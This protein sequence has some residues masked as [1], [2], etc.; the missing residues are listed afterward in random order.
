MYRPSPFRAAS[1][2]LFAAVFTVSA[3]AQNARL[4]PE[5]ELLTQPS[6]ADDMGAYFLPNEESKAIVTATKA[7]AFNDAGLAAYSHQR[8][9]QAVVAFRRSIE[10]DPGQAAIHLNLSIA[11]SEAGRAAEALLEAREA[12]RLAPQNLKARA[13]VCGVSLESGDAA[14]AMGCYAELIRLHPDDPTALAGKSTALFM[15]GKKSEAIASMKEVVRSFPSYGDAYNYLGVMLYQTKEMQKAVDALRTAVSID[16]NSAPYRFNLGLAQ[17][18]RHD[19]AG[20]VSQY[21]FLKSRSSELA[22]KL[23][24]Q[25]YGDKVLFIDK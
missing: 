14:S 15:R 21:E 4:D 13:A 18:A 19:K 6:L 3:A 10:L 24:R 17:L 8:Y 25:I 2:I 11:L 22:G 12:V 23:Y 20:A 5:R 16:P 1:L 7:A 9:D